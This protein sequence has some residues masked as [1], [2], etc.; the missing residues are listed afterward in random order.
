MYA[1]PAAQPWPAQGSYPCARC[2]GAGADYFA[3]GQPPLH[4]ACAGLGP[5]TL[6]W[7]WLILAY[8]ITVPFG[9]TFV[10]ALLA[11]IPYYLWRGKYP[12]RAKRYNRHVWIAFGVSCLVW[13]GLVLRGVLASKP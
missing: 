4:R 6:A 11:S 3:S 1:P 13:G 12:A 7:P 2:G 9:C 5:D 10:G 8:S